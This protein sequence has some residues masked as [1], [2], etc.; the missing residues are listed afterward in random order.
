M[1]RLRFFVSWT[2]MRFSVLVF[3]VVA[4]VEV[5]AGTLSESYAYSLERLDQSQPESVCAARDLLR[6][7]LPKAGAG[8]AEAV[9]LFRQFVAFD[10]KAQSES[11]PNFVAAFEPIAVRVDEILLAGAKKNADQPDY[12]AVLRQSG[13]PV[14][15]KAIGRW[16]E[17]GSILYPEEGDWANAFDPA[18]L[19][20]FAPML[21]PDLQAWIKFYAD[22]DRKITEDS[23]LIITFVELGQRLKR[24]EDFAGAYPALGETHSDVQPG[25]E[26][27]ASIFFLGIDNSEVLNTDGSVD[28]DA[29]A[30]W[31]WFADASPESRYAGLV[32]GLLKRLAANGNRLTPADVA[33]VRSQLQTSSFSGVPRNPQQ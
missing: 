5:R 4:C 26:S 24:W 9:D 27:L 25:I 19:I 3:V 6:Q 2:Q 12:V 20:E 23:G 28:P 16:I 14:I 18:A 29:L 33:F 32:G 11:W 31:Q 10:K 15:L 21:P 8:T 13:D 17:C 22:E 7:W 1:G 30:G